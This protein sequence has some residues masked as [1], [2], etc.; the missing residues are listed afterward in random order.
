MWDTLSI[1]GTMIGA[2]FILHALSCLIRL[3]IIRFF[4]SGIIGAILVIVSVAMA[5][6]WTPF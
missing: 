4:I 3:K 1:I 5:I 6:G 2:L